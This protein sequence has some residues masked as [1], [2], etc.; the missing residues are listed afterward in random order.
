MWPPKGRDRP[1]HDDQD[2]DEDERGQDQVP[3]L[4]RGNGSRNGN[5]QHANNELYEGLEEWAAGRDVKAPHIGPGPEYSADR[6][7][8]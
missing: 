1:G 2:R 4:L 3:G 6:V 5:E 7:D 8:Q